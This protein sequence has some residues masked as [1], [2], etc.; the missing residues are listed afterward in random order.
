MRSST[1]ADMI[2]EE[3]SSIANNQSRLPKVSKKMLREKLKKARQRNNEL[4]QKVRELNQQLEKQNN[5]LEIEHE[6]DEDLVKE[7][8]YDKL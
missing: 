7:M 5:I 8:E 6:E 2:N 3:T 1:T 4:M